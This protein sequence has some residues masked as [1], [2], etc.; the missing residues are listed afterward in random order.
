M[1]SGAACRRSYHSPGPRAL[2]RVE[3]R[4][5]VLA[6][7]RGEVLARGHNWI[8]HTFA[9]SKEIFTYNLQLQVLL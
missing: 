4:G 6:I 7:T 2:T 3:E 5:E 9:D 8:A 1:L